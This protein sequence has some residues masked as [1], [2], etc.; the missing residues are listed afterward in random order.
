[1]GRTRHNKTFLCYWK[2]QRIQNWEYENKWYIEINLRLCKF[3]S[4][5]NSLYLIELAWGEYCDP[6]NLLNLVNS[7]FLP[8]HDI[9][10]LFLT[11]GCRGHDRIVVGF[12]Q[13]VSITTKV[14]NSNSV[15]GEHPV[16]PLG[17]ICIAHLFS[18]VLC[19]LCCLS[20]SRVLYTQCYQC[21]FL[22]ILFCPFGFL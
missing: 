16:S 18:S 22:S 13:S 4:V 2:S 3:L 9:D 15:H 17:R 6:I 14:V 8:I 1:M 12:M 21:L 10:Y 11:G 20:S 5:F 7:V 19:S